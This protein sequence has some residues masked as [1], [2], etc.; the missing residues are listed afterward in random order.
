MKW[1]I[2][3]A[4]ENKKKTILSLVF[5]GAL[6]VYVFIFWGLIWGTIGLIFM[7]IALQ[8]YYFPT[9]YELTDECAQVK[10]IFATQKRK[11][12]DF[13]KVYV[14]KNGVLLSPFKRKTFLN[15][16]RGIFLFLPPERDEILK[17]LKDRISEPPLPEPAITESG[18]DEK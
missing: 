12:T 5:I 2:H 16:F 4:K 11:L 9:R 17:F 14:G 10:T 1:T 8:P 3:P 13:K 6:L 15:N 7:F 18:T